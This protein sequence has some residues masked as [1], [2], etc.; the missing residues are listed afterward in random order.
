MTSIAIIS[1][2]NCCGCGLCSQVCPSNSISLEP[3]EEGFIYPHVDETTCL[4]CGICLNHCP[5]INE[6]EPRSTKT[7]Y[8]ATAKEEAKQLKSSSGG[9]FYILASRFIDEWHGYVCGCVMEEDHSIRHIVTN[10]K[11]ELE[12]MRGSKYVQSTILDCYSEIAGLLHSETPVLFSGTPCQV[13]AVRRAFQENK[14]LYTV[15]V[16][17]HGTTSPLLFKEYL[18]KAY[19]G[20]R[21][22]SFRYK[23]P[24]EI[25]TYAF[26]FDDGSHVNAQLDPYFNAFLLGKSFR[27]SC[28]ACEY[29]GK[30]RA[31]DLTFGDCAN[32]RAYREL[33]GKPVSTVLVNSRNGQKLWELLEDEML[34]VEA[35]YDA[36]KKLNH[37][38]HAPMNQPD[39]RTSFYSDLQ[40]LS[41]KDFKGKYA[42]NWGLSKKLK[43]FAIMHIPYSVRHK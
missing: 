40:K 19:P 35:D 20:K 30:D 4:R 9:A 22:V 13:A 25:S 6:M 38:L 39:D 5:V 23:N 37:Q 34:H 33:F 15:D 11:N 27:Q 12:R 3:D 10:D 2:T 31:G 21:L 29:A 28:Y 32:F 16:V 36:E 43:R 7:A 41:M 26:T 8:A 17:C 18:K 24:Y 42:E 1:K 14:N